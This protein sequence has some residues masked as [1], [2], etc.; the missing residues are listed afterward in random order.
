MTSGQ[1]SR[2]ASATSFASQLLQKGVLVIFN[3]KSGQGDHA[4]PDLLNLLRAQGIPLTERA[5]EGK[6]PI[7]EFIDDLGDYAA[8]IGAG[9][10]GTVSALAY[11]MALH[12]AQVPLLA[13]PAGTANLIALNLD[14]P[15][16]PQALLE[17]MLAGHTLPLDL[18]ELETGDHERKGFAML[19][20]AGADAAMIKDSEPLKKTFG[21]MAYVIAAMRQINPPVTTFHLRINGS[22]VRTFRGMG[23]MIA[24]LGMANY[25]LPIT[26]NISPNDGQFTVI[27]LKDGHLFKLGGNLLDSLKVKLGLGDPIF[28][29][30]FETFAASE[31]EV[32]AEEPMLLQFDGEMHAETTPFK[33]RV[34]PHAVHFFT[35]QTASDLAT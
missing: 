4:L 3:P 29:D 10:D 31:L 8:V 32:D 26:T 19:A 11:A 16:D 13:F 25:R 1:T 7:A 35:L 2:S 6:R 30:N 24:N 12:A 33:A 27:L 15:D 17:L 9:G 22:E 14:I 23:I 34:L 18:G 20:G 28:S 5:L 21:T